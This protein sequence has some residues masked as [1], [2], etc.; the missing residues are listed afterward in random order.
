MTLTRKPLFIALITIGT[1]ITGFIFLL[2]GCLTKYD[3]RFIKPPALVIEKNGKKVIFSIEEF[4]KTTSYSQK[5]GM[6][7]KSVSITY[8][9]QTNDGETAE[10]IAVKKLK[11]HRQVKNFPVEVMGASGTTAWIFM[12]E[13]MAFDAFTLDKKADIRIL[14]EK[15]GSL[16]GKF[17]VER[18]FYSFNRENATI[19]FTATDGTKWQLN[20]ETLVAGPA[21]YRANEGPFL[22]RLS[23]LEKQL[24][25]NQV[26]LNNLYQ[27]KSNGPA[28]DYDARKISFAEY[29]K[30][31]QAY[32]NESKGLN[33]IRDSLLL[34]QRDLD[35]NKRKMEDHDRA[36]KNL[37]RV[38]PGFSQTKSNQDTASGQ[39]FGLYSDEEL[40]KLNDRV[41]DQ[42]A[43]DETVRRK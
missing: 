35:K 9:V 37:E 30:E 26:L 32:Y 8:S 33:K 34:I 22:R 23:V 5:G 28:K 24:K 16:Q 27:E 4:E 7:N 13:P 12:G 41:S 11:N 29:Q 38:N 36:I 2:K 14:E 43:Y 21:D 42:G 15:N 18:K 20:A 19:Y 25:E 10:L 39:W 3:E 31:L 6:T 40:E 17:P 1:F